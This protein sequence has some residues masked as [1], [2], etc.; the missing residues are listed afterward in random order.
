MN[1]SKMNE[2]KMNESKMN[3]SMMNES[4]MN[5]CETHLA[6]ALRP[7]VPVDYYTYKAYI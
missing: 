6:G 7:R 4:Q 3:E 1:E 5:E 2:S